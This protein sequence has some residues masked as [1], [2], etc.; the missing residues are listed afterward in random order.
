MKKILFLLL[1]IPFCGFSQKIHY[2]ILAGISFPGIT[3][4]KNYVSDSGEKFETGY[5][6][7][8]LNGFSVNA[9]NEIELGLFFQTNKLKINSFSTGNTLYF[10]T[11]KNFLWVPLNYRFN[12]K[13]NLYLKSGIVALLDLKKQDSYFNNYSGLGIGISGG[14]VFNISKNLGISIQ[15]YLNLHSLIKFNSN[16]PYRMND[17]GIQLGLKF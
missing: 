17:L 11:Q 7:G 6:L 16:N 10:E 4:G 5:S 13:N 2:E 9:K 12:F 1:L 8:L 3:G 15:P 14:K